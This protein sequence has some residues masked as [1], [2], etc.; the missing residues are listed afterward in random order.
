MLTNPS[1]IVASHTQQYKNKVNNSK[2]LSKPEQPKLKQESQH[3]LG[4]KPVLVSEKNQKIEPFS[5]IFP[6][7]ITNLTISYMTEPEIQQL[8]A[9]APP[10]LSAYYSGTNEMLSFR[11]LVSEKLLPHVFGANPDGLEKAFIT[12]G[13]HPKIL[14]TE[15][16]YSEGYDSKKLKGFVCFRR[17]R[18]ASCLKGAFSCADGPFAGLRILALL[19]RD[20]NLPYHLRDDLRCKARQQLTVL[21]DR[22]K[23]LKTTEI[24]NAKKASLTSVRKICVDVAQWVTAEFS[25]RAESSNYSAGN[26][27]KAE[28]SHISPCTGNEFADDDEFLGALLELIE[29]YKAFTSQYGSL[30]EKNKRID[31]IMLWAQVCECHKRVYHY[32]K[33]E[34]FGPIPFSPLPEFTTEPPRYL[35]NDLLDLDRIGAKPLLGLYKGAMGV[36]R[37]S[38]SCWRHGM[39]VCGGLVA[40]PL[41]DLE[42]MSHLYKRRVDHLINTIEH[43]HS[44]ESALTF[45][46]DVKPKSRIDF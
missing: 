18:A 28:L 37:T 27:K 29:A 33:L 3:D 8:G 4:Q 11:K 9:I 21:L 12:L 14:L 43:L 39:R 5:S 38:A 36:A 16:Y 44:L 40:L 23:P 20:N 7:E 17:W 41:L 22:M 45:L 42:A 35:N 24:E 1:K 19:L 6:R 10:I 31:I 32:V 34:F 2:T 26:K 46:K 30:A 25:V 15:S 13:V